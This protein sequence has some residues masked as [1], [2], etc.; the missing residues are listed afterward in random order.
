MRR[1]YGIPL[2]HLGPGH[3]AE[4]LLLDA[5]SRGAVFSLRRLVSTYAGN[6][7]RIRRS[8][9][10]TEQDFG[11]VDDVVDTAGIATF[12]GG[13]N[14]FA[15]TWYDQSGNGLDV[16][17]ATANAQPQFIAAGL[18]SKP[19]LRFDGSNDFLSRAS[20][21]AATLVDANQMTLFAVQNKLARPLPARCVGA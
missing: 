8:S 9:D 2:A 18:G 11:F 3:A 21:P 10:N 7:V 15:V 20:V 17:Q 12:I 1:I 16:T 4:A 14:G 6:C 5:L 19:T 13:G